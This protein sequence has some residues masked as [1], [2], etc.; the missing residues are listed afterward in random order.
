M[1]D[2]LTYYSLSASTYFDATVNLDLSALYQ[3]FLADLPAGALI[4]D[5]GC[6]SGRDTKRFL[7]RGYQVHAIDACPELVELA[8]N[9]TQ[10]RIELLRFQDIV[11]ESHYDAIWA[12]AS[13]LHVPRLELPPLLSQLWQALKPGGRAY[14]SFKS[15]DDERKEGLR[16]YTDVTESGLRQLLTKLSPFESNVWTSVDLRPNST[17]QWTNALVT[18]T[19]IRKLIHGG[20]TSPFLPH[21]CQ[22]I[23]HSIAIDVAVSFT[24]I[25]GLRLLFPDLEQ[26]LKRESNPAQIRFLTSDYLDVTDTE[27][28]S[29]L[30][31]L[32]D[33]GA[34][35]R[36]FRSAGAPF[37]LKAWIFSLSAHP[38]RG[39]AFIGSSNIS[40]QALQEA[41]EWN[42]KIEFPPD[43]GYLEARS[44]FE[45][46]FTHPN[47]LPLTR[48]W[49]A[50]YD[51]RRI[52]PKLS[53]APGSTEMEPPPEPTDV[54]REALMALEATRR[55]HYRRG[56]V[57][58]ATGL[59]KTWLA[60]FDVSASNAKRVL[61]VAH[62]KEILDQA[63]KTFLRIRPNASVG[64][65]MGQQRDVD[66]DVT[67]ASIQTLGANHHLERFPA[68]Y[69]DY[70]VVDE[71][72]HA[73]ALTYRQLLKHFEPKFL[74]GLTATPDRT[75]QA[76]ILSLC[77]DNLVF[78]C[79]LYDGVSRKLLVPF[80]YYGIYDEAIDYREIPWRSI[81]FDADRLE[82]KLATL[83][84]ARHAHGQWELYKQTRT[85]AFCV[86]IRHADFMAD[87]FAKLGI[88]AQA[89]HGQSSL[90]RSEAL[91][92][93]RSGEIEVL[94]SVDLFNEGV[95]LP[96]IDTVMLLRP[97]DSAVLFL[98][99]V[100]RGLRL[101]TGKSHLVILDFVGNDKAFLNRP[102]LLSSS[103][104]QPL[105][106]TEFTRQID[107]NTLALPEGCFI[108][109]D[110]QLLDFMRALDTKGLDKLYQAL[111]DMMGRRPTRLEFHR[112]G[113]SA[114]KLRSDYNNWPN[115]LKV[116]GDFPELV[117]SSTLR[118][119]ADLEVTSMNKSFK[120]ILLEAFQ[121]LEGWRNPPTLE[122]LA[123]RSWQ[124]IQRRPYL[125]ADLPA[126]ARIDKWL[127]YWRQNPIAAWI[128][129]N[130][131]SAPPFF[132]LVDNRFTPRFM[133]PPQHLDSFADLV[134]ELIDYRLALYQSRLKEV[135]EETHPSKV[136]SIDERTRHRNEIPYFPNLRIACGHFKTGTA[137]AEEFR[138]LDQEHGR[139]DPAKHFIAP[140]SGNSMDGGRHP[141][142]DGDY[143][144]LERMS[145][146]NAG[147]ITGQVV[148]I[149]R[150]DASGDDQYL[151]RNI[152][153][154]PA[155]EYIL[156]ANHPAYADMTAT[157]EYRTLARL[158]ARL[159]PWELAIG[160]RF[161]REDIPA[162][163]SEIFNPGSWNVGHVV[164]S[165]KRMHVLLVTLNKQGRVEEHRYKDHWVDN[166]T[167]HWQSQNQS[168]PE[169]KKGREILNHR[170][171]G[172]KIHLFIREDR[173]QAGQ[174][175]PFTYHGPVDYMS[176]TGSK[177]MAVLFRC[178]RGLRE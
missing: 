64:T 144:L 151:L 153:K 35:V 83:T 100:G 103:S 18:K 150:Q 14:L 106:W 170:Q 130:S 160:R 45:E 95:D 133:V 2:T 154:S 69:F 102:Q 75:D 176:H 36:I 92:G 101:A 17:T 147:S 46:L 178:P 60:A 120:M 167:F 99:Q 136:V 124:A 31:L 1:A 38:I 140:A 110:L 50:A 116:Q 72:H 113:A 80:H 15:G 3:R 161:K 172:I 34:Q 79:N 39:Q 98:Q 65:Y 22:S 62:R 81:R 168:S 156:R 175:S 67:V 74:L 127:S 28:L 131:K 165:Q 55:Q 164:L 108:N 76:N 73:D 157:D 174:S 48:E 158:K 59:G 44:R 33:Q 87:Q 173:L 32:S 109:Y 58:M 166:Q 52:Q 53:I 70:I 121:E 96:E 19:P 137:D 21:L 57:V 163:F 6:G 61:F 37:H 90:S 47:S 169:D 9:H 51:R 162:L 13:L 148:V 149:E 71:F 104:D 119:F 146:A 105:S 177:P 118:F 134:Q 128:G 129:E 132:Q 68:N 42:Y 142:H 54:Q 126:D 122:A 43:S 94:F 26:A 139:L 82:S 107:S 5:L 125:L 77:D 138:S 12:C 7:Q 171:L 114:L 91:T 11:A 30:M 40:R 86:S 8:R 20:P 145:P 112:S 143:L 115:F 89:V 66:V 29:N 4:L 135:P 159:E 97:T 24:K 141:I 123:N 25:A 41:I 56:L 85:L 78:T 27:A 84:R 117:D 93:L 16:H 63:A 23:A 49:I 152:L 88:R 10:H 155:G 111:R